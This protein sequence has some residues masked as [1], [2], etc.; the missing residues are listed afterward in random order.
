[1]ARSFTVTYAVTAT[2]IA[3]SATAGPFA[4][5]VFRRNFG[6]PGTPP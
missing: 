1:M 4:L 3:G 2:N 5:R 6:S